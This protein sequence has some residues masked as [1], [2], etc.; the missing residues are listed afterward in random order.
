MI[1]PL[2]KPKY[3]IFDWD[4][5]LVSTWDSIAQVV[6][7]V[8]IHFDMEPWTIDQ[9]KQ[10]THLSAKDY[11]PVLFGE[12]TAEAFD[13]LRQY[14]TAHQR[15]QLEELKAMEGGENFLKKLQELDIP[16]AIL[17]NKHGDRLRIEVDHMGWRHYFMGV[18]GSTDFLEDKPSALPVLEILKRF[19]WDAYSTWFVG[20]TPVD[21]LCAKN[22]GCTPISIIKNCLELEPHLIFDG[23]GPLKKYFL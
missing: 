1:L 5:T 22:S 2:I 21:W 16:C 12:R 4:N 11:F 20:D 9:I 13:V 14:A 18:F 3:I 6:N 19:G 17:S 15:T 7:H 23:Y 8:L 10:K